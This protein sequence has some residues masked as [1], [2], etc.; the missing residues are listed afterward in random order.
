MSQK[1]QT[2]NA[3]ARH[4]REVVANRR[5]GLGRKCACGEARPRALINR[6]GRIICAKDDRKSRGQTEWDRHHV[7]GE[8]NSPVFILNPV[9]DHRAELSVAQEDWPRRTLQNKYGSPLLAQAARIRGS[10]DLIRYLLEESVLPGAKTL[11][12]LDEY[13]TKQHGKRYWK[14]LKLGVDSDLK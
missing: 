1:L 3:R 9:N 8:A 13:L 5:I 11:E 4:R 2:A 10:I 7:F 14:K 6:K 12:R